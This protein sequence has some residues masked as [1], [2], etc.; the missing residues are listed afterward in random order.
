[1]EDNDITA[2]C[3]SNS[4]SSKLLALASSIFN[5]MEGIEMGGMEMDGDDEVLSDIN[6]SINSHGIT[7]SPRKTRSGKIVR[8]QDE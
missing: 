1:L 3:N 8:Y 4:G 5:G 2:C 6:S 7:T